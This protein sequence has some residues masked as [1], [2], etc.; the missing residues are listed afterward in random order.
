MGG[1]S[2]NQ[3]SRLS[4]EMI[5]SLNVMKNLYMVPSHGPLLRIDG[6]YH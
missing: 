1:E 6:I 4:R 5:N 2:S 3:I